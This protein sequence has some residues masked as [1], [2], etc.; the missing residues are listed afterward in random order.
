MVVMTVAVKKKDWVKVQP[1]SV[2]FCKGV[3]PASRPSSTASSYARSR[4]S[5]HLREEYVRGGPV[6]ALK[7]QSPFADIVLSFICIV[8][9]GRGEWRRGGGVTEGEG[10]TGGWV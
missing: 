9:G 7:V 6:W 3:T 1:G 2:V 4:A 5:S 10:I 8:G